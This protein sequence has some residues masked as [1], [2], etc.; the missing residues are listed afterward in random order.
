M[1]RIACPSYLSRGPVGVWHAGI[2][3]RCGGWCYVAP[4]QSNGAACQQ[5]GSDGAIDCDIWLKIV[6]IGNFMHINKLVDFAVLFLL[7]SL[8]INKNNK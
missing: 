4:G 2:L 3:R 6:A 1:P 7:Q 5:E 8:N